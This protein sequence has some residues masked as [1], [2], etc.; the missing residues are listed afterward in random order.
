MIF[1]HHIAAVPISISYQLSIIFNNILQ[2]F[3]HASIPIQAILEFLVF[4]P[5]SLTNFLDA[6][7]LDDLFSMLQMRYAHLSM[8]NAI[9]PHQ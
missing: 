3:Q 8:T 1:L 4:T 6:C 9:H 5:P 7:C 2:Y